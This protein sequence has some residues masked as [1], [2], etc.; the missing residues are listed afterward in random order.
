MTN[1]LQA[2]PLHLLYNWVSR[3]RLGVECSSPP[4][5]AEHHVA[6]DKATFLL[7]KLPEGGSGAR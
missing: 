3:Y 2:N 5:S 6:G 1:S 4:F 7:S